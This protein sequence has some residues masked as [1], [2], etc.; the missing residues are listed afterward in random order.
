MEEASKVESLKASQRHRAA[1]PAPKVKSNKAEAKDSKEVKASAS[2]AHVK[3]ESAGAP[4]WLAMAKWI[5][6]LVTTQLLM[7]IFAKRCTSQA[8]LPLLLCLAQFAVSTVLSASAWVAR[9]Q[10]EVTKSVPKLLAPR[11]VLLDIVPLSGVWTGGFVMF[12]AAA[13][14][15][16][17]GMVN[18]VR[19]MEPLAT[20]CVGAALGQRFSW[21]VLA[22][23][24]PICGGVAMASLTAGSLSATGI[25]LATVSNVAFCCRSFCL[26]RLRRNPENKLD[27]VAVFF[28]VSW[29][30]TVALPL[31]QIPLEGTQVLPALQALDEPQ[32]WIFAAEM[33]M[34]SIFFFLYQFV[35]LLVMT[36]L[37]PLAFSVLTPVV[38]AA[39]TIDR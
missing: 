18:V 31:L 32:R 19:C 6:L 35:Q 16:S 39:A 25:C 17:P 33:L 28:N 30:A 13:L 3:V 10:S 9:A 1:S 7:I 23:L 29:A 20:V 2:T 12:N 27:D 34:S 24:V 38:K 26:Q 22:T 4:E 5:T 8:G 36:Q 21:Q 14:Y 15:M 11:A 37:S